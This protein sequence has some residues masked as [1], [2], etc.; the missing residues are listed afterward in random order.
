MLHAIKRND[1]ISKFSFKKWEQ[2]YLWQ[3][4]HVIDTLSSFV[5]TFLISTNKDFD[6]N[7]KNKEI[8]APFA[9]HSI[10]L[11][12]FFTFF[13]FIRLSSV[14]C[15]HFSAFLDEN[16]FLHLQS[17][18]RALKNEFR[19]TK[20]WMKRKQRPKRI[21]SYQL[22]NNIFRF[23]SCTFIPLSYGIKSIKICIL[24]K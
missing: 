5:F 8:L 12:I 20:C 19:G 13:T 22:Q 16:C 6:R 11:M 1:S 23:N 17:A 9:I 2:N 21:A 3:T 15:F 7:L 14:I 18:I 4:L 10:Y 24:R